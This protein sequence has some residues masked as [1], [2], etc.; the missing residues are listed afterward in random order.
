MVWRCDGPSS[1][2]T[3]SQILPSY[4]TPSVALFIWIT[5][6]CEAPHICH[7]WSS[8]GGTGLPFGQEDTDF[9]WT[10]TFSLTCYYLLCQIEDLGI[11]E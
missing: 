6:S 2:A 9:S 7:S 1:Q 3:V 10:G 4:N 5:Q 11:S 8:R